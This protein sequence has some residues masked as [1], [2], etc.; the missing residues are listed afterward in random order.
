VLLPLIVPDSFTQAESVKG[1]AALK[2]NA[3]LSA[4]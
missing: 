1:A 4:R 3:L 2:S